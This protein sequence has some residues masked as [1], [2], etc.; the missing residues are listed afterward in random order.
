[1]RTPLHALAHPCTPLHTPS[2]FVATPFQASLDASSVWTEAL[3]YT[4]GNGAGFS[5]LRAAWGVPADAPVA[6]FWAGF[7][8]QASREQVE[9]ALAQLGA[10]ADCVRLLI[11]NDTHTCIIAGRPEQCQALVAHLG[12]QAMP[13]EQGMAGHCKEAQPFREEIARV[14]SMLRV[15]RGGAAEGV[16]FYTSSNGSVAELPADGRGA[17]DLVANVYCN[18]ADFPALVSAAAARGA[19]VFVEV[20][21]GDLRAAAARD[22]LGKRGAPHVAV[23]FDR[24]GGDPWRQLLKMSATLITNGATGCQ[25]GALYHPELLA[26]IDTQLNGPPVKKSVKAARKRIEINGRFRGLTVDTSRQLPGPSAAPDGRLLANLKRIPTSLID[27]SAMS[28]SSTPAGST[29]SLLEM[30]KD[31]M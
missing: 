4:D 15:P 23:A 21:A 28:T 16:T 20:G 30:E 11:V 29:T 6:S 13:I 19:D 1:M 24:R 18:T 17:G 5:A 25:I 26:A 27:L 9:A 31:R 22:V 12:C 3:A 14:H 8:V 2:P 7:A 10:A